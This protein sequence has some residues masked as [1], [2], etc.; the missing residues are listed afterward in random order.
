MGQEISGDCDLESV[1]NCALSPADIAVPVSLR[2]VLPFLEEAQRN[3][4]FVKLG[5]CYTILESFFKEEDLFK[6]LQIISDKTA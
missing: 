5:S 4:W 6:S 2:P 3:L 1:K